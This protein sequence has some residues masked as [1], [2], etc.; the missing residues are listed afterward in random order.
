M[1]RTRSAVLFTL[2]Y[3]HEWSPAFLPA[4]LQTA[5]IWKFMFGCDSIRLSCS[6]R[7]LW[8]VAH[9]PS[10]HFCL[11]YFTVI[12]IVCFLLSCAACWSHYRHRHIDTDTLILAF[13]LRF[14][15]PTESRS[16]TTF[17]GNV[18]RALTAHNVRFIVR[19]I[20]TAHLAWHGI[21]GN[22]T[23]HRQ[24]VDVHQRY[25]AHT[26]ANNTENSKE[27]SEFKFFVSLVWFRHKYYFL[28]LC[29]FC[30]FEKATSTIRT[31]KTGQT[32]CYTLNRHWYISRMCC[33]VPV[34]IITVIA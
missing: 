27:K 32:I 7:T 13:G 24:S 23:Q 15:S 22:S 34:H 25:K 8:I 12:F 20:H 9:F 16:V 4:S 14:N 1:S 10:I 26:D 28:F 6:T 21:D 33:F 11:C 17:D 5:L 31:K 3:V 30:L 18:W 19:R 2:A 29:D